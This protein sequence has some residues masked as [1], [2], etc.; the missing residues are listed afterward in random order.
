MMLFVA[1]LSVN[2]PE[3]EIWSSNTLV[4]VQSVKFGF[5]DDFYIYIYILLYT[6]I[7]VYCILT[8]Q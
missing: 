7:S 8:V 6:L 1:T 5:T 2:S 3:K 4:K